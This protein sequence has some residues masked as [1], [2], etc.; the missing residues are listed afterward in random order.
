VI[1]GNWLGPNLIH[2]IATHR[3][4]TDNRPGALERVSVTD[5]FTALGNSK[6]VGFPLVN[7]AKAG[8]HEFGGLG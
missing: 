1:G 7:G 6:H 8:R 3:M 4:P 2:V 5:A